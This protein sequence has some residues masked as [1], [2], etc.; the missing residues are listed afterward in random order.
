MNFILKVIFW[1]FGTIFTIVSIIGIYL[2]AFYFGFFGVLEKAEPNINSTYPKELLT[3]K[4][5]SQLEHNPSNKQILF[6]DTHVHSTYSS[7]AFLWSLPLNNGEGPHPVSD[8]CDYARFCSALDFWVISDHAEAATPTKWM[9]AKKAVRQC[10]AIHENSETPDLISFLGFEWTQ[11]DPDKENHY[12]HKNVMFLETDEESVPVMPIGSGGVATDGM[13]SVDRLPVVRSNMLS[14]AL[15][16]FKN[17]N[18]YA[19]LITFSEHIV[20]TEDCDDD[21]YN[22]EN[23]C[24]FSALTP[25]D[26]FTA[27]DKIESDSIVIPHGNTWGFY[28][29]SESSWDKQLSNEH[30]NADKQISFE[31]MSGH[32]NSEEYRPWTAS[33]TENNVQFCPEPSENYL[34]SCWQAGEIIKERCLE[35]QNSEAICDKRAALAR[36]LYIEGGLS[37]KFAVKGIT[38]EE[39]LD[40]GQCKDCFIPAFNYRPRGSAQYAL[41]LRNS[42]DGIEQRFKFGFIASSDNHRSRPGTGYKPIDRMVTTEA[43]GPA[44]KFVEDNLTPQE[45]KSDEPRKVNLEELDIPDPFSLWEPIRQSSFFTTGGLAAVHVENRSREGIWNS[46]KRRETYATSGPRILLWF[47][48][49]DTAETFPMGTETSKKENPIFEVKALGSFKQ[50]PGCPEDAYTALGEDRVEELCYDEC[51]NPSD[52]RKKITRI[53]VIRV[54]PQEYEDQPVDDRI[55]DSWKVHDCDTSEV[56]CSFTFQDNEFLDAKQDVSYYVRAIEEPSPTINVRGGTCEREE[57]GECVGFKLCTQDWKH[58]RD[59]ESCSEEGEHRA[60]SSPIYVDYLS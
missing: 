54:M 45:E 34:P 43:N 21:F 8:A 17:R 40:S 56:G 3:K 5:Q 36:Q 60:W 19:D 4:I 26:L 57:N 2:L 11:I 42:Q 38:P 37:G 39:W 12:G 52:E 44:F 14:M 31:I 58:P 59:V 16:D 33:L 48:L 53:E 20:K 30:N 23:S 9:E 24:Y 22:S 29:P 25:K 10:N 47:N 35:N 50:K 13:R 41:A 32:G 28:T 1:V 27:L 7:D 51:Y 46:F 55:Q 15:V 6:G 18:R 49:I